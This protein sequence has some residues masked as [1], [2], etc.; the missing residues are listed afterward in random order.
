MK[1]H[2]Y[3]HLVEHEL[4]GDIQFLDLRLADLSYYLLKNIMEIIA[5]YLFL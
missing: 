4:F 5:L 3:V 2:L 1:H